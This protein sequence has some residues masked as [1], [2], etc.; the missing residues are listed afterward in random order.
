MK[1]KN[2]CVIRYDEQRGCFRV[3][4]GIAIVHF[5]SVFSCEEWARINQVPVRNQGDINRI[6]YNNMPVW[7][8]TA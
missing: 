4:I 6:K 3:D 5:G 2:T 8:G 7:E 1:I